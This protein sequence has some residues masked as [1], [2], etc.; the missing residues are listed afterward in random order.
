MRSQMKTLL[1]VT[2]FCGVVTSASGRTKLPATRNAALR[3]WMA[4]AEL[5]D[6][7]A[8][9]ATVRLLERTADGK[10]PWDEAKLGG[11]LDANTQAIL[12]M[13][14]AT[15]LRECYWGLEFELGPE[16]PIAHLTKA[17]M[18]G[19]LN[20]LYGM[21]LA[22]KGDMPHAV[23]T[24]LAGLR[25]SQHL[26]QGGSIISALTGS[27]I[28]TSNM[29]ALTRAAQNRSLGS[30]ERKQVEVAVRALPEMG[31]DWAQAWRFDTISNESVIQRIQRES[32]IKS[33]YLSYFGEPA[34]AGLTSPSAADITTYRTF[35]AQMAT[36][37]RLPP[38]GE[39]DKVK[40]LFATENMLHPF[41]QLHPFYERMIPNVSRVNDVRTEIQRERQQLIDSVAH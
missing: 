6:L 29:S 34:P 32:D 12:T 37:L 18:L 10:A 38:D 17:R 15:R 25:F 30:A 19:R 13:Q 2:L 31:F 3:Y 36:V 24:W 16:T 27:A 28:L 26:A 39:G 35:L 22:S 20:A 41:F 14:R 5:Q 1:A 8:D 9:D 21:R 33:L 4:F 40:V 23:E 7:R 11:I